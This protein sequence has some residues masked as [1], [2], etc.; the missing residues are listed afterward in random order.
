[1]F[2]A[3]MLLLNVGFSYAE[4]N[5]TQNMDDHQ[6]LDQATNV[7]SPHN[8]MDSPPITNTGNNVTFEGSN[9][10]EAAAGSA[11]DSSDIENAA[12]RL[13]NFIKNNKRLPAYVTVGGK[14]L[15]PAEFLQLSTAYLTGKTL[16]PNSAELPNKTTGT[17]LK[18]SITQKDYIK[19]AEKVYNFIK[20]NSRAPNYATFNNQQIK[21]EALVWLFARIISFK[22]TNQ[23]LPNYVNLENLN[24]I[25][26]LPFNNNS[27]NS[28]SNSATDQIGEGS[29]NSSRTVGNSS[30]SISD[31]ISAAKNLKSFIENNKRLPVHV[32]VS[33]QNLTVAQF[34]ELMSRVIV[35]VNSG[36]TSPLTPRIV[37]E[38]PNPSGSATGQITKSEYIKLANKLLSFI[39]TYGRAPNYATASIG[40]VS[41]PKLVY[42]MSRILSF[43]K[44][45]K[46]LP[47]YVTI[48]DFSSQNNELSQ[49]LVATANCQVN[50]PS[51]KS[52]A[53]QLTAG[54]TSAWDKARA[55]F[56]WV[57]DN[58]S[59]SFY[60]NTRY[61]AVGTLKYRTGNCCDQ[62]HLVVALARAAGLPARYV[63]GICTFSTGTYGHVWAQIYINGA[64]YNADATSSKNS[65]GVIKSWNTAIIRGVYAS[66]PF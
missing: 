48:T 45:N 57:R 17:S 2:F 52:L 21:F 14:Q 36:Q 50:D 43:Y 38:A 47:N 10:L 27:T 18:G 61:G 23:R 41:Y 60:Y 31:I 6:N 66:L 8:Q 34:L 37:T 20:S 24:S 51:I 33:D 12:V 19:L 40:S 11:L 4:E 53:T 42:A 30:I 44:D 35:Q 1:M 16:Q 59:Y 56:N 7:N 46:R 55:I 58:I 64:W 63:H 28:S 25:K 65:L 29:N 3:C 13:D 54:L 39:G 22:A 26:N 49:Y 62:A 32:T 9:G 5:V 15:N